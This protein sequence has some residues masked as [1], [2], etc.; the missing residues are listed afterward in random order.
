V[1]IETIMDTCTDYGPYSVLRNC[2]TKKC[3][4]RVWIRRFKGIRGICVGFLIVFD[5][6][7]NLVLRDVFEEYT[8]FETAKSSNTNN[9]THTKT[10]L[11][12]NV[13]TNDISKNLTSTSS[14]S[15]NMINMT[16]SDPDLN[17]IEIVEKA[18]VT[19]KRHVNQLFIRGDNVVMLCEDKI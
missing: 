8:I 1:T 4:V 14:I 5:K 18:L 12:S 3:R 11:P 15:N 7:I 6:H 16:D 19:K 2:Y 13:S 17:D 9:L 10:H